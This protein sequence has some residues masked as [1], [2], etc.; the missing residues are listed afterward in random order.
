MHKIIGMSFLLITCIFIS[1]M[2][3]KIYMLIVYLYLH[4]YSSV[5]LCVVISQVLK[6]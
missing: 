3:L 6:G 2:N 1:H 5:I 4:L